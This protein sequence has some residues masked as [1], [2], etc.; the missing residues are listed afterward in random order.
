MAILPREPLKFERQDC[1][2]CGGSGRYSFNQVDGDRCYGCG[3]KGV[4]LT[5]RG[6][7]AHRFYVE[8]T[9]ILASEVMV[10]MKLRGCGWKKFTVRTIETRSD[11]SLSFNNGGEGMKNFTWIVG[12][13][14]KLQLL[15]RDDQQ[16]IEWL[17]QALAYEATLGAN[18]KPKSRRAT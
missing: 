15:P 4:T 3:G 17:N 7:A 16:Q 9:S 2:R 1:T 11:G 5:K 18:G 13:A 14:L 6:A 10:G 8:L 12:P